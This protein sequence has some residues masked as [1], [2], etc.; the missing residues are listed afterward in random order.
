ML[1]A[2][3]K[4]LQSRAGVA[5]AGGVVALGLIVL[6][7]TLRGAMTTEAESLAA[8][9]IFI[10]STTLK[11]FK[12]TIEPGLQVPIKAPSGG[13][14]GYPAELCWWTRDGQI[15]KGP[16]AVLLNSTVDKP[17]PTFCPDCGRLVV[18][19]NPA[20]V[21]GS[22]PPPTQAEYKPKAPRR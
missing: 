16:Y 15:R 20:P 3:R 19:H 18:G 21:P 5:T 11:P 12:V 17:G 2:I 8:S 14:T 4:F 9:R 13:M 22:R 7:F 1:E 6:I 10:D